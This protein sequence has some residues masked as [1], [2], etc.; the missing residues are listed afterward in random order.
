MRPE[1]QRCW[2]Y[3]TLHESMA[4]V[5]EATRINALVI[6]TGATMVTNEGT[7]APMS[8]GGLVVTG[9]L[10]SYGLVWAE[11]EAVTLN[12]T[13]SITS[14]SRVGSIDTL[15]LVSATSLQVTCGTLGSG[16]LALG[17]S[18]KL[19]ASVS[20]F[21]NDDTLTLNDIAFSENT[22]LSYA[23]NAGGKSGVLSVS[24][25]SRTAM[26]T[27]PGATLTDPWI[28]VPADFGA[29]IS[30]R[31]EFV[32]SPA[33]PVTIAG[34]NGTLVDADITWKDGTAKRDFLRYG[35]GAWNYDA[36]NVG[37]RAR[38]II[39]P[40]P[41]GVDGLV[42][43]MNSPGAD[44]DAAATSLDTLLAT[45]RFDPAPSPSN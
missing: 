17:D 45:M 37:H 43:V 41:G 8:S 20:G 15:A 10:A 3:V 28:P 42:I 26:V 22:N 1:S 29:W 35:T 12:G 13:V 21:A 25:G 16:T 44:F 40:G 6:N 39:L 18:L 9:S 27:L 32:A 4:R 31:P 24:D 19:S 23:A 5:V 33:R 36:G 38:F 11:G 30:Q 14:N 7:L 2:W 34:R